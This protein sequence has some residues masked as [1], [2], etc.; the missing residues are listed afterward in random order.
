MFRRIEGSST[1]LHSL[2][3]NSYHFFWII[4]SL[5]HH[6]Y[7]AQSNWMIQID[8]TRNTDRTAADSDRRKLHFLRRLPRVSLDTDLVQ[9]FLPD[10]D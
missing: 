7:Q 8:Q 5:L 3:Y 9:F 6:C 1:L 2:F 10:D 4:F